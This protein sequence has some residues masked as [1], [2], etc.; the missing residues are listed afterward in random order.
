M[1]LDHIPLIALQGQIL[2]PQTKISFEVSDPEEVAAVQHMNRTS[3]YIF[4]AVKKDNPT[5][6]PIHDD[7]FRTGTLGVIEHLLP[8]SKGGIKVLV[9][10]ERKARVR[11][12]IASAPFTEVSLDLV[13]DEA[14]SS[15]A[16]DIDALLKLCHLCFENYARHLN[17]KTPDL[18][19]IKDTSDFEHVAYLIMANIHTQITNKQHLLE[20]SH[21]LSRMRRC[22]STIQLELERLV[23]QKELQLNVKKSVDKT[24]RDYYLREHMKVIKEQLGE[25][26][27]TEP[28]EYA[29]KIDSL[30]ASDE[31]KERLY[32]ELSKLKRATPASQEANVV[33][34]YL[35]V[36][37]GLPWGEKTEENTDITNAQLI[38][39]EDHY[40]LDK[41]KE[42]ILEFLAVRHKT[43]GL[44]AP[45]LCLV[46][47]PGVGKTS[48]AK[49]IAK[50][51]NRQYI[52]LSLGGLHDESELRGHRKT[53]LGAMPG[54]IIGALRTTKKDNPLIL[55]DEI[56]KL[57]RG[58]RGDP[59]SALLEIL[60]K[61]QSTTFRDN[62][63][64]LPY[65][66]SDVMFVCTANS[67]DRIPY[68]L[69]DRLD[70][71]QLFS[72]T[73][74]EKKQISLKYLIAKQKK[75]HGLNSKDMWVTEDALTELIHYY[76]KEAGV[77]QLERNIA[78][79]C[80]KAVKEIIDSGNPDLV[81]TIDAPKV[82]E[83]LGRRKFR[84]KC[85]NEAPEVGI[86]T[87]LAWTAVGGDTLSIEVNKAVGKGRFKLTGNV[88]KVMDE[89][90]TAAYSF[91]RSNYDK[92]GI[93][94][95]FYKNTDLHIHIPEGATPKDGPSAGI[96]MATAMI[97]SL[98]DK[99][100][101]AH[102]AMTGEITIRGKVL[103]IGGVK[104]KVLAAKAAG[105]TKVLLPSDN[106]G[107]LSEIDD[108]IKEGLDFVLVTDIHEVLAHTLV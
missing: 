56:D 51:L 29:E 2:F 40:G 39:D 84:L 69:R 57:D 101:S 78:A 26:D 34:E 82:G 23:V 24:Q 14:I 3:Q 91:I 86:V 4:I 8:S 11:E 27:N 45:I 13:P 58:H 6:D 5:N 53:Y 60:D 22:V 103:P 77:R 15:S 31:V 63:V 61:E 65:D 76:T 96:T 41:V 54:R 97:S 33:R 89:S 85:P 90:A 37:L 10:G 73:F 107:E 42:R 80:R 79:L 74:E 64:E 19:I 92:L 18:A 88:G 46:G 21:P 70:I 44:S 48:I 72:Y 105:I 35:E 99:P 12:F 55:L 94:Q 32:K 98:S 7:I 28:D 71:I 95:D 49:S 25:G 47:P 100:A 93:D 87:G 30:N 16:Q 81:I 38:L 43:Q 68:A 50:S 36:A 1:N 102:V 62:Y 106:E 9:R 108:Y 66:I 75:A 59:A 67:L 104:E 83:Y 20:D 52:R 17:L